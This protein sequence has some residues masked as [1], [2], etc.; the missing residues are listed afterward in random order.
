LGV[1]LFCVAIFV[2][3]GAFFFGSA[4]WQALNTLM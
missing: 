2:G 1:T 4:I 3:F